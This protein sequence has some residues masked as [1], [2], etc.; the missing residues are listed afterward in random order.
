M[1]E[2]PHNASHAVG[3]I[4]YPDYAQCARVTDVPGLVA[5]EHHI[6][7]GIRSTAGAGYTTPVGLL[8]GAG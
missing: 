8:V 5:Q 4:D 3:T 2:S 1:M 7:R 6:V